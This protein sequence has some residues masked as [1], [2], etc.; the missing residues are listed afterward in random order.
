ML[1]LT[2][3]IVSATDHSATRYIRFC[4]IITLSNFYN[5]REH[6]GF[7]NFAKVCSCYENNKVLVEQLLD[8]PH[9]TCEVRQHHLSDF[10]ERFARVWFVLSLTVSIT[11]WTPPKVT[12]IK[13]RNQKSVFSVKK[14]DFLVFWKIEKPLINDWVLPTFCPLFLLY[15]RRKWHFDHVFEPFC[16]Q[17][18][19]PS[20]IDFFV[21]LK[22]NFNIR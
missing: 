6:R 1:L 13:T 19:V 16:A 15:R 18:P 17:P 2:R 22:K 21:I 10:S 14:S 20:K 9:E 3:F 11:W 8:P 5:Y 12:K 4:S 7:Y